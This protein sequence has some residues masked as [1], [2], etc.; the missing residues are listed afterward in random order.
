[1]VQ[2]YGFVYT[3]NFE[4]REKYSKN[5]MSLSSKGGLIWMIKE[6]ISHPFDLTLLVEI[7]Y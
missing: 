3:M 5:I 2:Y 4:M 1:M 7:L 6:N